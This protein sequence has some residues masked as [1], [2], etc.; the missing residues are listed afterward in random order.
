VVKAKPIVDAVEEYVWLK[1]DEKR[2]ETGSRAESGR[3]R[4]QGRDLLGDQEI[5]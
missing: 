3:S 2:V 1:I 5:R 4:H